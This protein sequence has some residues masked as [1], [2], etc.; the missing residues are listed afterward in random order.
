MV[1]FEDAPAFSDTALEYLGPQVERIEQWAD[2]FSQGTFRY[3]F[4]IVEDWIE[5]PMRST[6]VPADDETIARLVLER[7]PDTID[8]ESVDGTFVLWAPGIDGGDRHDFGVRVGSNE[9]GFVLGEKRPGLFWAPSEWHVEDTNG[10]LTIQLKRDYTW[11]HLIHEMQH[12]QGLNTHAPGNGWPTGLGQNQ[13]PGP[14]QFSAA[15]STWETFLLGWI[16][17]DQVHCIDPEALDD[18]EQFVL[19]PVEVYGGERRMGVIPLSNSDVVVIESRR[20]IGWTENWAQSDRGLLVYTVN[21]E[22]QEIDDHSSGDCGNDP[23]YPK[24]A[25]YLYPDGQQV[26]TPHCGNFSIALVNEGET[27]TYKGLKISLEYSADEA[28]YVSVGV[29]G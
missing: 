18:P 14:T 27:L 5:I 8:Y 15:L 4:Q 25:Y 22:I 24:W 10:A 12:E 7:F 29:D 16:R 28:D 13:Y 26:P 3:S 20:P 23:T 17:D 19:T 11:A 2:F 9:G 6:E 21:P 1:A